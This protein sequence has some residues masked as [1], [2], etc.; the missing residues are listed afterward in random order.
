MMD[1]QD[2][3]TM[4]NLMHLIWSL[5]LPLPTDKPIFCETHIALNHHSKLLRYLILPYINPKL[6]LFEQLKFL[7]AGAHLA[8]VLFTH[9]NAH[10]SFLP[11]PLY[12][13]IQIMVKNAFFC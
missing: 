7:S 6:S 2:V 3:M 11:M 4:L 5:P 10:A 8:Y 13:D 12:P 9:K 1:K